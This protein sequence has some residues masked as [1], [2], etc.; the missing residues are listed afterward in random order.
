MFLFYSALLCKLITYIIFP[1]TFNELYWGCHILS[2][3]CFAGTNPTLRKT[4][5][6]V[7]TFLKQWDSIVH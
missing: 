3:A 6:S 1:I 2:V 5:P 4:V 7:F